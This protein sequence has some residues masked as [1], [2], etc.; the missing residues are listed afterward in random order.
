[1]DCKIAALL[2]SIH[3]L[4]YHIDVTLEPVRYDILFDKQLTCVIVLLR[5]RGHNNCTFGSQI[6]IKAIFF[7]MAQ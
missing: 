6:N 4:K 1:M 7:E 3:I 5:L 2:I